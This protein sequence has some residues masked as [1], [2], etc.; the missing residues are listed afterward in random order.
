MGAPGTTKDWMSKLGVEE[1]LEASLDAEKLSRTVASKEG[2]NSYN[3]ASYNQDEVIEVAKNNLNM[4]A[5]LAMPTIFKFFFPKI[6]LIAWQLLVQAAHKERDFS[7]LALGIPRGHGKTT[8]IKL[9]I[10]Y[11]ILFTKK[12]FIL[13]IG[14]KASNAENIIAD[15]ID[16][17]NENNIIRLFGDWKLG[18]EIARQDLKK[19]GFRGR[20]ITIAAI[21]AEGSL[22]GLNIK[23]ERPDVM[24]FDDV[25]TA[26]CAESQVQSDS[27][28]RWMIGTAM[29]AKSP[30]GCLYIF[31]GNMFAGPNS[32][33]KK[34]KK[35]PTWIKFISGA[36]LADG[37]ALWPELRSLEELLAELDNDIEM[38]HPEIFFSEVMNDTEVGINSRVDLSLLKDWP[39]SEYDLPQGK[40]IVIDPATDK[41][42]SDLVAIG[43]FEVFDAIPGMRDVLEERLSPGNTIRQALLLALKTG[44]KV[45]GCE[46]TGYQSTL[47]YWFNE[48][49]NGLGLTGFHFVEV[50]PGSKSKNFRIGTM[51][52][53]LMAGEILVHSSVKSQVVTQI[54]N[55]NPMK[56]D[57]VDGILDLLTYTTKMMEDYSYLMATEADFEI[58]E[59]NSARVIAN[60]TSF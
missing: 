16:I 13:V 35:N 34:L 56:R 25:Q 5:G 55:W 44:T 28:E 15:V 19:F 51:M 40:F 45:I 32:I 22:R 4:L 39:Y 33:L 41:P 43:Y 54:I 24:V 8:L 47:L 18:I 27:L 7:Q 29:K 30:H 49:T 14:S 9:F 17:L 1:K 59:A 48:I 10:I 21:G 53:G 31:A 23:N 57:N 42:G 38:G 12:K 46:G 11:C 36:I 52:K 58:Q 50:H 6:L 2:I 20:N 37:T 3:E 26:E 60:N